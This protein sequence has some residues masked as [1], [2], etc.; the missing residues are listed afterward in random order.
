M[1]NYLTTHV[2]HAEVVKFQETFAQAKSL[3]AM[4]NVHG[5]QYVLVLILRWMFLR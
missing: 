5:E 3:D 2:I 4:I 1:L